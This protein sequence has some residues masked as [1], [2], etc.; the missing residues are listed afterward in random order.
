MTTPPTEDRRIR[1]LFDLKDR[2]ALVTGAAETEDRYG[3]QVTLALAEAG[4]LVVITSRDHDKA[5]RRARVLS[6]QGFAVVGKRL[7]LLE[8]DGAERV[9]REVEEEHGVIDILVNNASDNCLDPVET[10][11]LEDWSR[12]LEVNLTGAMRLAR[13]VA[14]AMRSQDRGGV[15]INIASIYGVVAPDPGIY[16]DSGLNSPLVYGA[17]KA[18]LLQM[19]RYL[20]TYW[21]PEIRVNAITPGGLWNHQDP[22]FV[23]AYERRTPLRRMAGPSDLKGAVLFLASDASEW[24]TGTNLIVDGG[25][26]AW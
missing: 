25:W 6:D 13:A 19:T 20:A 5:E 1:D 23:A 3:P 26:T 11:S 18:A 17:S 22:V 4:A 24:V 12:V 15:I 9:V 16:G 14:P 7:D 8:P 2:L 10:V 21:A